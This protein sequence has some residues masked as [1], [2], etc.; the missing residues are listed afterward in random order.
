VLEVIK[1]RFERLTRVGERELVD[2]F[3]ILDILSKCLRERNFD[4]VVVAECAF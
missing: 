4:C 3:V 2:E 1:I